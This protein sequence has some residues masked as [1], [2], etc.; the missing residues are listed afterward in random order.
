MLSRNL[1]FTYFEPAL[2]REVLLR[3]GES[4]RLGG[5]LVIGAHERLAEDA[6]GFQAWIVARGIYRWQG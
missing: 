6:A 4:L 1:V 3:L 5:A 2:Q